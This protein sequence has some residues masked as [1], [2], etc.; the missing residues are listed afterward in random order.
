MSSATRSAVWLSEI[1]RQPVAAPEAGEVRRQAVKLASQPIHVVAPHRRARAAAVDEH[2]GG[3][4]RRPGLVDVH[5]ADACRVASVDCPGAHRQARGRSRRQGGRVRGRGRERR[6]HGEEVR[7]GRQRLGRPLGLRVVAGPLDDPEPSVRDA[8]G[9]EGLA[10]GR[11]EE[12]VVPGDDEG[13]HADLAEPVHHAPAPHHLPAEDERLGPHLRPPPALEHLAGEPQEAEPV[14]VRRQ[15]PNR[16]ADE[17]LRGD[18]P[19]VEAASDGHRLRAEPASGEDLRRV[20]LRP[21]RVARGVE[22]DEARHALRIAE[23]VLEGDVAA[24]RM[25]EH[26]PP[27]EPELLPERV[28]VR[29]EVLPGHRRHRRAGRP[30]VA[31]VVVEDDGVPVGELVETASATRGRAPARRA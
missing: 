1:G 21:S 4:A 11:E 22:Q 16:R 10:L 8:G 17:V 31:A 28:G 12:V 5:L 25:P 2:D 19:V 15:E 23:R 20:L 9:E 27:L 13:R 30:P 29:G 14:V 24:E 26:G 3:R 6:R 18:P 7:D